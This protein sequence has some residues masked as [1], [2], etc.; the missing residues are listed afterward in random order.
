MGIATAETAGLEV[1]ALE[2]ALDPE[3]D[4]FVHAHA[5]GT[6]FHLAGWR[7][8]VE[9]A[10]GHEPVE[11]AAFREGALAGILP[12]F[13]CRGPLGRAHLVSTPYGVY[14]GPLGAAPEVGAGR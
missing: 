4:R 8:A 5:R 14:G 1:R 7:R 11:L 2:P 9:R 13:R 10:F 3:R 6:L 12:L